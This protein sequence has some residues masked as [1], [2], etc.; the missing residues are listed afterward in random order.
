MVAVATT[1]LSETIGE[2]MNLMFH[3]YMAKYWTE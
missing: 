1:C 3:E 2:D